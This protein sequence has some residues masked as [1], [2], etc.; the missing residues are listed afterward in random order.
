MEMNT[1]GEDLDKI[2][3]ITYE[4]LRRLAAIVKNGDPGQTY[5][6]TALV[7]EAYLKLKKSS[8]FDAESEKHFKRIAAHAMRQILVDAARRESAKKRGGD[9]NFVTFNEDIDGNESNVE[10]LLSLHHALNDLAKLHSRQA[11]LVEYRFFGGYNLLEIAG[12]LDVSESTAVRDW[13]T[14]KAWL[15]AR[16]KN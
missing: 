3:S 7:N 4:E 8:V 15:S 5:N 10:E 1:S 9:L 16:L 13:R 12:L 2:F 11:K 14:A 6:P